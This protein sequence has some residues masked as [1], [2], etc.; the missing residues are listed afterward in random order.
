MGTPVQLNER[1]LNAYLSWPLLPCPRL[2]AFQ[3][4][5]T[6]VSCL[7]QPTKAPSLSESWSLATCAAVWLLRQ[8]QVEMIDMLRKLIVVQHS[9]RIGS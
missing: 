1:C 3:C 4:S 5:A 9:G 7:R 6:R 2:A 8:G